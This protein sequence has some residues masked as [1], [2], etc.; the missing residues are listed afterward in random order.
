MNPALTE[1]DE[2]EPYPLTLSWSRVVYVSGF[3]KRKMESTVYRASASPWVVK[4]ILVW[5]ALLNVEG[6]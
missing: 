4:A 2:R 6:L 1:T 3:V 5:L